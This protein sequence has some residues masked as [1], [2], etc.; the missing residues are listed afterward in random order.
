MVRKSFF[1]ALLLCTGAA[2]LSSCKKEELSSKKELLSLIFEAS[3]N[4]Q[5]DRNYLG[6]ISGTEVTASLA[7]GT[8]L[9]VLVPTIEISPRAT[10]SPACGVPTD[11]SAPFVYTVTAEDATTKA[12]TVTATAQPAPYIGDWS[13]GPIDL[14]QSLMHVKVHVSEQGEMTLELSDLVTSELNGNS[15]KGVFEPI[16][17][18]D[19]EIRVDQTH[20]WVAD[21]WKEETTAHTFMYHVN[22]IQNMRFYYCI[23]YPREGW[24]FQLNLTRE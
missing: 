22:S 17:R 6:E 11:F 3:K 13:G 9:T 12:F 19:T 1:L 2:F 23:C 5:L 10:L 4:A 20:R 8:D 21:N 24:W 7:F 18:Q 16:S 15:M 14:G